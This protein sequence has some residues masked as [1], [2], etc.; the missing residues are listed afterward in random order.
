MILSRI[1]VC[2]VL[3]AFAVGGAETVAL[4]IARGLDPERFR[5]IVVA[6][7]DP[8]RD[9]PSEMRDRFQ[10]DGVPTFTFHRRSFRDPRT[11]V[12]F[13][14]FLRRHRPHV[15]HAHNRP[16]D[17][18]SVTTARWLRVP[19]CLWTRHLV[20][21]D[22]TPRQIARYRRLG[23]RLPAVVAVSEAVRQHCI[24][25]EGLSPA[26]VRTIVNGIDTER[27]R[28]L[29]EDR[30]AAIRHEIGL[31]DHELAIL[32]VGR[33]ANQKNPGDFLR[34]VAR[35]RARGLSVRGFLCGIGPLSDQ[36]DAEASAHGVT[37]LGLRSDV[38]DLLASVDL[39]ASTSRVEG[40]PL[41]LMEAMA[42]GTAFVGPDLDQ[43]VQ[44]VGDDEEL[45]GGLFPRPPQAGPAPE[46]LIRQWTE[47]TARRLADRAQRRRCGERGRT[48]IEKRFSARAMVAAHA[49]L[50]GELLGDG[51]AGASGSRS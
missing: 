36:L 13:A 20:Y 9:A 38:P 51:S 17:Y 16:S 28:P 43:V 8:N 22:F 19:V 7:V 14:L 11:L 48:I 18:W 41:N 46:P 47:L 42:A 31:Q 2:Q 49:D 4:E 45:R 5:T 12:D 15:V 33:L 21:E 23:N 27:F 1:R 35:L 6:L 44:L 10:A 32:Q 34:L 25:T 30:R 26:R 24:R 29:P 50:Y 40:L 39:V 37:M 3:N